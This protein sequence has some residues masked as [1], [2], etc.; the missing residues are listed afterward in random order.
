MKKIIFRLLLLMAA[1]IILLIAYGLINDSDYSPLSFYPPQHPGYTGILSKNE[2][3]KNVK[4]L[5]LQGYYGPEDI[6]ERNGFLYCG[7][8]V[9]KMDF[10]SNGKILKINPVTGAV[11][12]FASLPAWLGAIQFDKNGNLLACIIDKGLASIDSAGKITYLATHDSNNHPFTIPNDMDI[13]SNGDIY[14]SVTSGDYSFNKDNMVKVLASAKPQGGLYCYHPGSKKLETIKTGFLGING[15]TLTRNEDAIIV[16]EMGAYRLRKIWISG[17]LKG[18]EQIII[19]N[20]PGFPNNIVRRPDGTF[21]L[22]FT[23][24]R[25]D[26]LDNMHPYPLLKKIVLGLPDFMK[27]TAQLFGVLLHIDEEGKILNCYYDTDGTVVSEISSVFEYEG[28]L[29][30]GGDDLD[31]INYIDLK[32]LLQ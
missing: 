9:N 32:T 10:H 14:F 18:N 3:L 26:Q 2:V 20:L 15:I 5:S 17:A 22:A 29:F 7:A 21:W 24:T 23:T 12:E 30:M 4:Y 6:A 16:A 27:P 28:K 1:A 11:I 31:H 8:R 25:N 19:D 13:A